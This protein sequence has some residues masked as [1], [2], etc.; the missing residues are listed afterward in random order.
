MSFLSY[1]LGLKTYV[2]GLRLVDSGGSD[3]SDMSS[4]RRVSVV[5]FN[6]F[7]R[8]QGWLQKWV[9]LRFGVLWTLIGLE[10]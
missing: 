7:M 1:A 10:V 2:S 6:R 5:E 4:G 9:S 3:T 8:V